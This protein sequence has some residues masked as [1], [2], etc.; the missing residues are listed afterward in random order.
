[1]LLKVMV[2]DGIF[3]E[4]EF[5]EMIWLFFLNFKIEILP[6]RIH[7]IEKSS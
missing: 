6:Q 5:I 1:M 4:N 7:T 2:D 3:P